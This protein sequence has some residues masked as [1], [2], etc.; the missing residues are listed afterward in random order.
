M[1]KV[2]VG[3]K[4][5]AHSIREFP[6]PIIKFKFNIIGH[7]MGNIKILSLFIIANNKIIIIAYLMM[8]RLLTASDF[9]DF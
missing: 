6:I 1:K 7:R 2:L 3:N 4:G 5:A 9:K 8:R